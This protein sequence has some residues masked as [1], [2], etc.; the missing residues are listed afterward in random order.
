MD[1]RVLAYTGVHWRALACVLTPQK[2]R[3]I[4]NCEFFFCALINALRALPQT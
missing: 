3:K 2:H 4:S 1:W